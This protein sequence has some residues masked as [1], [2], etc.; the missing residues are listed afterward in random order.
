MF[1]YEDFTVLKLLA[2]KSYSE[3]C[4]Q[5]S[6]SELVPLRV[7]N[8]LTDCF[9][10][11]VAN[12]P[13]F[14]EIV[15]ELEKAVESE[16]QIQAKIAKSRGAGT[17]MDADLIYK[18]FPPNIAAALRAGRKIEPEFLEEVTV[19]FSDV[20]GF[21]D[22]SSKLDARDVQQTLNMMYK[23][24]D[25]L[26]DRFGLFR[27]EIIGDAYILVG[28]LVEKCGDHTSRVAQMGVEMI[29]VAGKHRFLR[30]NGPQAS[31]DG[32][33]DTDEGSL[34]DS[35]PVNIRVGI[36]AGPAVATVLGN[37]RPRFT[38]LGDT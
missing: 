27:M 19:L 25:E 12:R 30:R 5:I 2:E 35:Y 6:N 13:H 26:V 37:D 29:K 34:L 38:L 15:R 1:F 18:L 8:I 24:F 31:M 28:N 21:T 22:I 4:L 17:Q 20:V 16:R 23:D 33:G 9:D 14:D 7:R 10:P 32:S 36:H 3:F 11:I